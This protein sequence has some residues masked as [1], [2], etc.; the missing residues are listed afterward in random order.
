M[1]YA[2]CPV[3]EEAANHRALGSSCN[4]S[5]DA[6]TMCSCAPAATFTI[7]SQGAW[8][9][10]AEAHGHGDELRAMVETRTLTL[11]LTLTLALALTLALTLSRRWWR[12]GG[13]CAGATCCG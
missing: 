1:R 9:E 7:L 5:P 6:E 2:D 13:A 4:H 10:H 11:T 12:R 8:Q 3:D